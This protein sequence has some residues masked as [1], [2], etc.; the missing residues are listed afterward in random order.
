MKKLIL[1]FAILA[2]NVLS[3]QWYEAYAYESFDVKGKEIISKSERP[4]F[5]HE[6]NTMKI[7]FPDMSIKHYP[8]KRSHGKYLIF[9]GHRGLELW[10]DRENNL[11][12]A[13][14]LGTWYLKQ[15]N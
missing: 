13:T 7:L 11:V 9:Q 12:A 6:D 15:L 14:K 1:L 2:A 5:A 8:F 3:A 4:I 10:F